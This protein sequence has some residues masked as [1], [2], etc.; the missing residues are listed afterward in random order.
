MEQIKLK[1]YRLLRRKKNLE[2]RKRWLSIIPRDN[3]PDTKNT[4]ACEKHWPENYPTKLYY[5]KE[6][7]R[8][9]HSV[10]T[11]GKPNEVLRLLPRKGSTVKALADVRNLL[12]DESHH[13]LEDDEIKDYHEF[14]FKVISNSFNG[15]DKQ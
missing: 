13:C 1:A 3:I 5:G 7:T 10:F 14:S 6:T 2:E 15:V 4:V 8:D 12:P 11:C 9:H